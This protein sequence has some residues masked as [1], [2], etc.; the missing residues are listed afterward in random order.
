MSTAKS[1]SPLHAK[2]DGFWELVASLKPDSTEETWTEVAAYFAPDSVAYLSGMTAPSSRGP[3]EAVAGLK[4]LVTFW[5]ITERRVVSRAVSEDGKTIVAEMNNNLLIFGEP[6]N[7]FIETEIVEFDEKDRIVSYRLHTDGKPI[8]DIVA[9]KM[10]EM[11]AS[12]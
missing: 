4:Q 2:L 8:L 11:P 5:A 12:A 10:A 1:T 6:V 3:Q 7:D 9:R